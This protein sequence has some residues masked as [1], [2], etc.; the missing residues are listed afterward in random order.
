MKTVN[1]R[2]IQRSFAGRERAAEY[3]AERLFFE[4]EK[5]G[6]NSY[7]LRRKLGKFEP[8]NNLTL[9]EVEKVLELWKL[10]GPHGG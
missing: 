8:Q 10:R 1:P 5:Q 2:R 3:L 6:G 7:A 9:N 4:F